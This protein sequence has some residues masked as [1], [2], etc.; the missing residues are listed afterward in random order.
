MEG[1]LLIALPSRKHGGRAL[2]ST[3]F[4]AHHNAKEGLLLIALPSRK[5]GGRALISTCFTAH[6]NAKEGLLLVGTVSHR[7]ALINSTGCPAS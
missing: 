4:T 2:I 7:Q 6:D 5:H 1:L 3:C